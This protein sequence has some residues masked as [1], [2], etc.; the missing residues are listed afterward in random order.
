MPAVFCH[1]RSYSR[2]TDGRDPGLLSRGS[3]GDR[4]PAA[5][6]GPV[7]LQDQAHARC[8]G[9]GP[10]SREEADPPQRRPAGRPH[11]RHRPSGRRSHGPGEAPERGE[12]LAVGAQAQTN[13]I[14]P[15]GWASGAF[16]RDHRC[17]GASPPPPAPRRGGGLWPLLRPYGDDGPLRRARN[18]SAAFV[19]GERRWSRDRRAEGAPAPCLLCGPGPSEAVLRRIARS[20]GSDLIAIGTVVSREHGMVLCGEEGARRS[21]PHLGFDHFR[22]HHRQR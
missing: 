14:P 9:R 4:H 18:R 10:S 2:A 12:A 6:R 20:V 7:F 13:P 19:P 8:G 15:F 21:L 1:P 11:L 3:A 22:P 16:P 5:R 17:H